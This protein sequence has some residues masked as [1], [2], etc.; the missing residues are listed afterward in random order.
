MNDELLKSK[1]KFYLKTEGEDYDF[2]SLFHKIHNPE[3]N[4]RMIRNAEKRASESHSN[5]IE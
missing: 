5:S 4:E 3:F 2:S 1:L